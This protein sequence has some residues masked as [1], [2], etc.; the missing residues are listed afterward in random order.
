MS[1][2]IPVLELLP[3]TLLAY[4]IAGF[5]NVGYLKNELRHEV[6]F[7]HMSDSSVGLGLA[8]KSMPKLLQNSK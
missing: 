7:L 8:R 4:Q 3:K 6:D 2:K 1:V 5:Q